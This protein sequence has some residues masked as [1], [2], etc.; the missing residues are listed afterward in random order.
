MVRLIDI[1]ENKKEI[2]I[3]GGKKVDIKKYAIVAVNT[4][5]YD[6]PELVFR[7]VCKLYC[8]H[9]SQLSGTYKS[10]DIKDECGAC[11]TRIR[12]DLSQAKEEGKREFEVTIETSREMM[13]ASLTSNKLPEGDEFSEDIA[14]KF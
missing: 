7:E 2:D 4:S 14:F 10:L 5:I 8:P 3:E 6:T 9:K 1:K 13:P 12:R 11:A